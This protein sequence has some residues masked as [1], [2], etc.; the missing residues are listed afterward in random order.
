V[1][2]AAAAVFISM[3]LN[4][5]TGFADVAMSVSEIPEG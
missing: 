5:M 2:L 3:L 1:L 4:R